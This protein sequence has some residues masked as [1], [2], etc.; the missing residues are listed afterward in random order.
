MRNQSL[1]SRWQKDPRFKSHVD[2]QVKAMI[3][4]YPFRHHGN[5]P[6]EFV[7]SAWRYDIGL[8]FAEVL[9]SAENKAAKA[10]LEADI[11]AHKAEEERV[12]NLPE[13]VAYRAAYRE[14]HK[15]WRKVRKLLDAGETPPATLISLLLEAADRLHQA[16]KSRADAGLDSGRWIA[17]GLHDIWVD[18]IDL[19][20]A[21]DHLASARELA[22]K[23]G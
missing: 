1:I 5:K 16:A 10:R 2:D 11:A 3:R 19:S 4:K 21:C 6:D 18:N 20:W 8:R 14:E 22:A 17:A 12:R 9:Q 15:V 23:W 13:N 7:I